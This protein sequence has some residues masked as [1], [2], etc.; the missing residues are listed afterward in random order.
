MNWS[1]FWNQ[2][3]FGCYEIVSRRYNVTFCILRKISKVVIIATLHITI[4]TGTKTVFIVLNLVWLNRPFLNMRL[5]SYWNWRSRNA[6]G[7]LWR[8]GK[9][10]LND[11]SYVKKLI[12]R[13]CFRIFAVM[14]ILHERVMLL[15]LNNRYLWL[16]W[17][18]RWWW[19]S[20]EFQSIIHSWRFR[21]FWNYWIRDCLSRS[22][23]TQ[24]LT[25]MHLYRD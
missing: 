11:F 22:F 13:S 25:S 14:S 1:F 5:T 19:S 8:F 3:S 6:G 17:T 7:R 20:S 21:R 15:Y 16:R 18:W 12:F 23:Q 9:F 24:S 4:N 10:E 2:F